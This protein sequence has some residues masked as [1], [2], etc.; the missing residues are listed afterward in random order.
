MLGSFASPASSEYMFSELNEQA[1]TTFY[2]S[3][4]VCDG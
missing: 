2:K 4:S 1:A 3:T